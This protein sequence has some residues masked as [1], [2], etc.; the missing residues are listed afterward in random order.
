MESVYQRIK[1]FKKITIRIEETKKVAF[2]LGKEELQFYTANKK[3]EVE[4][5]EFKVLVGG[6]STTDNSMTFTVVE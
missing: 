3:W 6:D 2:A 1:S 5:G 4:P